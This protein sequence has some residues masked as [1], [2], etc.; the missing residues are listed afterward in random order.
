MLK[1][2]KQNIIDWLTHEEIPPGLPLCDFERLRYELR[3][4]DVLLIE[5]RSRI[6]DVIRMI[7]QSPWSHSCLYIGRLHDIDDIELRKR[8]IHFCNAEPDEQ[9]VI[10]GFV[11]KGTIVS[12]LE[13]YKN[14][15]LRICRPRGLSRRDSQQVLAHSI[16]QLGTDYD[17]RQIMDLAR[18]MLP[19]S[20]MPRNW[21]SSLFERGVGD[22]TRT[23]CSTMIAD[24]FD[25]IS[26][27]ILPLVK[28]HEETGIELIQRNSRMFT[29]KDFDYSPY[30][31][32]IKYPF[33]ELERA[34][35]YRTLPWNEELLSNDSV[36]ITAR[37]G[38]STSTPQ[39]SAPPAETKL[40]SSKKEQ[41]LQDFEEDESLIGDD[42]DSSDISSSTVS[43]FAK[44]NFFL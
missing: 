43:K 25:S 15:H 40:P 8:I 14:D 31:D 20:I 5:G 2:L 39:D 17:V 32:I 38:R 36:G 35:T 16:Q 18:F 42:I 34:P 7:T 41:V 30:F 37:K 19:W 9:L 6:S 29:P 26:F 24:A 12:S 3:P 13:S 4:C 21:R 10:E 28:Q 44:R 22:T 27:P 33:I 23:V 1:N 11:G